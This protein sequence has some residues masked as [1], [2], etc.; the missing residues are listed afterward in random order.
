MLA[1]EGL[2]SVREADPERMRLELML[3]GETVMGLDG[4]TD[5]ICKG[6]KRQIVSLPRLKGPVS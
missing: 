4:V 3:N 2:P 1:A 5:N 6:R